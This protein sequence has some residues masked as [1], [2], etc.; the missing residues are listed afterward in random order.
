MERNIFCQ[1]IVGTSVPRRSS[2]FGDVRTRRIVAYLRLPK[3]QARHAPFLGAKSVVKMILNHFHLAF[4]L[5]LIIFAKAKRSAQTSVT[6]KNEK[7][8]PIGMLRSCE[9]AIKKIFSPF[10][11]GFELSRINHGGAVYVIPNLLR[12]GICRKTVWNQAAENTP[13]VMPYQACGLDKKIS[14]PKGLLYFLEVTIRFELMNN[15]VADRGLTTWLRHHT[16]SIWF[17]WFFVKKQHPRY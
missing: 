10:L 6:S 12:Y 17:F 8:T 2:F 16:F 9:G 13:T 14:N 15:G 4:K 3:R 5:E 7:S 1:I 11:F